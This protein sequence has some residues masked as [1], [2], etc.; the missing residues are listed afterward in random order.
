MNLMKKLWK[1]KNWSPQLK[2]SK[3]QNFKKN[4]RKK[5]KNSKIGILTKKKDYGLGKEMTDDEM[6]EAVKANLTEEE[7]KEA[8]VMQEKMDDNCKM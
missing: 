2:K 6:M 4:L 3:S 5:R 1:T 8:E 7:K